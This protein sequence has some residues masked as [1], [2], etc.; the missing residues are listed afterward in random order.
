MR[1]TKPMILISQV[2]IPP[3]NLSEWIDDHSA[4]CLYCGS[5]ITP[6]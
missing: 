5:V 6:T 2:T 4:E 1:K 3:N